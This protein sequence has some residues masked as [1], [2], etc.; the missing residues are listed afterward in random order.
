MILHLATLLF[1]ILKVIHLIDWSWWLV[2]MP[3]IVAFSFA[4]LVLAAAGGIY[5]LA[6][7]A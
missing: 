2:F 3:S 1:V 7:D 6:K 5:W 4:A